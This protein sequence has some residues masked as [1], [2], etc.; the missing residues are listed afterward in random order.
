M[1]KKLFI[2]PHYGDVAWS[3][4]GLIAMNKENSIVVNIF[5]PR[6]RYDRLLLKGFTYRK[7]KRVEK[8]FQEL[9]GIRII[10]L[11]YESAL[12]RGRTIKEL[13]DTKLNPIEKE[14]VAQIRQF[15]SDFVIKEGITEIYSPL[16]QRNQIDHVI[17]KEAVSGLLTTG[18]EI[19]YYEDFPDFMPKTEKGL[20]TPDLI[21]KKV[22]IT[23][24]IEEKIQAV[25][26]YESLVRAYFTSKESLLESI[27]KSPFE[28]YW[29]EKS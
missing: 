13:I 3:C 17:V 6:R 29:L 14:Q 11:N 22:D 4:A 28:T 27:R 8:R 19:Y 23:S 7:R 20:I 18:C 16:A 24:V 9:F 1:S 10:Y 21:E 12:L 5:P 26:L 2:E 25:I 15:I